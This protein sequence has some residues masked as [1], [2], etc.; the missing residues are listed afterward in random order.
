MY[1]ALTANAKV[2]ITRKPQIPSRWIDQGAVQTIILAETPN[3]YLAGMIEVSLKKVI[4]DKTHWQKMLKNDVDDSINLIDLKHEL[5]RYLP[6]DLK[7][8]VVR[9]E[10][11]NSLEF[12]VLDYPQKVKSLSF[13]KQEVI[14]GTLTGIKGQYLMFD[15]CFVLNIRK[16]QGYLVSMTY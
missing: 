2:G 8:Y 1:L 3:R 9:D 14:E 12:P 7:P 16:H 13:D 6:D 4:S 10:M 11:I 15:Y 5:I